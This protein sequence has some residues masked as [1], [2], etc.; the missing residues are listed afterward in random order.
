ME[1]ILLFCTILTGLLFAPNKQEEPLSGVIE[2]GL[3]V[4]RQQTLLLA[5]EMEAKENRLPKTYENGVLQTANYKSWISGFFPGVLWYLYEDTP[6]EELKKYA[7]LYTLRVMPA[8]DMTSTHD[9]GFMLYCSFGN[10]YRLTGNKSYMDVMKVGAESLASRYNDKVGAIKSWN[11][12]RKWQFPV[13]IDNMMNLE[14]LSFMALNT[15]NNRFKEIA[16]KHAKTTLSNHF[17]SDNSCYHVVSYD[18]ITGIPHAKQTHQG[19]ADN[20]SWARGQAWALYGY[21]M[22]Y[23]ETNNKVYLEQARKVALF[24][25]NHPNLPEDKVPYWDFDAPDIPKAYRDASAAAI[26]ASAFL[27][28]SSLD[29]SEDR[30]EWLK[31]GEQQIRSLSSPLYLAEP[32]TNGGFILKHSVGN[33]NKKSEVDVPLTYAD[34]YYVEAL[35]RLKRMQ[36]EK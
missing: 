25:K 17:R 13:I 4:S 9:L 20:S 3:N 26:M 21:T 34:Y 33:F 10:G 15:G 1:N 5:K 23:R 14:F 32:N 12:N 36:N 30:I 11:S 27:E 2:R 18:T 28:L 7:E 35:L 24:I 29:K 6:T 16:D 22:M 31:L 8:K 19:Y